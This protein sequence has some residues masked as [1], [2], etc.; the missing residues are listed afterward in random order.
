MTSGS[1][2][3]VSKRNKEIARSYILDAVNEL[4]IN[5][6][7][8]NCKSITATFNAEVIIGIHGAAYKDCKNIRLIVDTYKRLNE[9]E[10]IALS[11]NIAVYIGKMLNEYNVDN[12]YYAKVIPCDTVDNGVN[13]LYDFVLGLYDNGDR[14]K[15][16][17]SM[18]NYM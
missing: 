18:H 1:D 3:M 7:I 10:C 5:P 17:N 11:A 2:K 12:Q 14:Q 4:V 6:S 16:I 13:T 8:V 15:F 9:D